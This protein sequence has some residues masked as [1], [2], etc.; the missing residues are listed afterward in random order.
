MAIRKGFNYILTE[1]SMEAFWPL[2]YFPNEAVL[3]GNWLA[4]SVPDT[5]S[6]I[7]LLAGTLHKEN[8]L[9]TNFQASETTT[10]N[11]ATREIRK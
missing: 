6:R 8:L 9:R 11:D 7:L 5:G 2:E 10:N 3:N 1:H 4:V